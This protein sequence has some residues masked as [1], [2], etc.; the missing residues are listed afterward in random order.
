MRMFVIPRVEALLL[1]K[2]MVCGGLAA[3]ISIEPKFRTPGATTT[4]LPIPVRFKTWGEEPSLSRM[5]T[6]PYRTP[7]V[8][9]ANETVMVQLAPAAT[10]L[11]QV[12]DWLEA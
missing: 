8:V 10:L 1:V 6:A 4:S 7:V 9:G 11:P 12:L 2:V 5:V 3:P